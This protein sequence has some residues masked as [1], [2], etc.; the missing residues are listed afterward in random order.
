VDITNDRRGVWQRKDRVV[1]GVDTARRGSKLGFIGEQLA[2]MELSLH[3]FTA[4]K[5]L[6]YPKKNHPFADVYA[7]HDGEKFW[8][9]VKTRNKYQNDGTINY[10]YKISPKERAFALNLEQTNPNT[11]A[12]C[13]GVSVV[14]SQNSCLGGEPPNSYSCYFAKLGQLT[15]R[16]GMGMRV[17]QLSSYRC[18]AENKFVPSDHDISDCENVFQRRAPTANDQKMEPNFS[19]VQHPAT[20]QVT[21]ARKLVRDAE[22]FRESIRLGWADLATNSLSVEDQTTLRS[23]IT[24]LIDDLAA[25]LRR[26]DAFSSPSISV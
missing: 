4:I 3:G 14:V 16:Q 19:Q 24:T 21:Q 9:S 11:I 26:M 2:L 5:H 13:I 7:E 23:N 8:I 22:T 25:L 18:L 1:L 20:T 6:N 17:R 12:A 10:C 15:D